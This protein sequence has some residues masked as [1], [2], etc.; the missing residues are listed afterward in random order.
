MNKEACNVFNK[1]LDLENALPKNP[2]MS[3]FYIAGY[4]IKKKWWQWRWCAID[5]N[6]Y[7]QK[8]MTILFKS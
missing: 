4:V 7:F 3:L 8:G 6:F 5:A 2:K 1:L